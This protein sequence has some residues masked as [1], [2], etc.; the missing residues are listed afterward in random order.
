MAINFEEMTH[1]DDR[2][3]SYR[4]LLTDHSLPPSLS[5]SFDMSMKTGWLNELPTDLTNKDF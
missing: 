5:L 4:V 1:H 3:R 2:E